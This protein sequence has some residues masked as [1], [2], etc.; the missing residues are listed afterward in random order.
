MIVAQP[1]PN[2]TATAATSKPS[3]PTNRHASRRARSVND[4]RGRTCA[5]VSLQ[6]RTGHARSPQRHSHLSHSNVAGRPPHARSRTRTT[7]R[8]CAFAATPQP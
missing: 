4:A 7:R 8:P 1:T 2:S 6:V 3:S 5:Q